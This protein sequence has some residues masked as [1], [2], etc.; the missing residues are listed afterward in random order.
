MASCDKRDFLFWGE[1]ALT[2][3]WTVTVLQC[4]ATLVLK[5]K[6][7]FVTKYVT[8]DLFCYISSQTSKKYKNK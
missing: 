3:N 6:L 1:V 4:G 2:E 5:G 7:T 8:S